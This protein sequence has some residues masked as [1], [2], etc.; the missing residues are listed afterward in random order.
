MVLKKVR[1]GSVPAH[2][3][4]ARGGSAAD[5]AIL[6]PSSFVHDLDSIG[7]LAGEDDIEGTVRKG[8]VPGPDD[9]QSALAS[10]VM[11]DIARAPQPFSAEPDD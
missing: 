9:F 6:M 7:D 5:P 1:D 2:F 11:E 4:I 3:H 8:E 10:P